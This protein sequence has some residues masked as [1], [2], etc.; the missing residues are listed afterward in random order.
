MKVK[1]PVHGKTGDATRAN[2]AME[3]RMATAL[4]RIPMATFGT[5]DNGATMNQCA[6][7]RCKI[8]ETNVFLCSFTK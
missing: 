4:R 3:W 5:K 7:L 2:G 6:E 8:D 1:E